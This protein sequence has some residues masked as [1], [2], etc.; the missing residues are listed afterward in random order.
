MLCEYD[1]SRD[2]LE[3][4]DPESDTIIC[5]RELEDFKALYNEVGTEPTESPRIRRTQIDSCSNE[6]RLVD[7]QA[8]VSWVEEKTRQ[9][10][11]LLKEKNLPIIRNK[12][13]KRKMSR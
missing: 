6:N 7:L 12:S 10:V 1:V 13:C 2:D 4:Y 5:T 3:C 8:K 9:G 11:K